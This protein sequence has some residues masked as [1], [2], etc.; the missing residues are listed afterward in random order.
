MIPRSSWLIL[1]VAL[2]VMATQPLTAQQ[3]PVSSEGIWI[4]DESGELRRV[5]PSGGIRSPASA[6]EASGPRLVRVVVEVESFAHSASG[7]VAANQLATRRVIGATASIAGATGASIL[8]PAAVEVELAPRSPLH[9]PRKS[10][11]RVGFHA[12]TQ[13]LLQASDARRLGLLLDAAIGAGATYILSV[14][15]GG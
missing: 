11:R 5:R 3:P 4:A 1:V 12:R 6:R 8:H 9:D 13:V 14:D 7:A 2:L 15:T 10:P